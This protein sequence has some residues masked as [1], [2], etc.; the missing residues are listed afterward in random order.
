M[1]GVFGISLK[2]LKVDTIADELMI[3]PGGANIVSV[4]MK[5]RGAAF[6]GGRRGQGQSGATLWYDEDSGR[7]VTSSA[8]ADALPAWAE[9]FKATPRSWEWRL[10]PA[11]EAFLND[12]TEA[13][14][15]TADAQEGEAVDMGGATFPHLA[16]NPKMYRATPDADRLVID[17]ALAAIEHRCDGAGDKA[18]CGRRPTL[19]SVSLSANDYIGHR[20]GP[21]SWE[22]W[23]ELLRLDAEL[24]RFLEKLDAQFGRDGYSVLLTGDHG[25]PHLP[26]TAGTKGVRLSKA[27]LLQK[28]Q[29]ALGEAH[30]AAIIRDVVDSLV[31]VRD[32]ARELVRQNPD[33]D[34]LIRSTLLAQ[35]GVGEVYRISDFK[36]GCGAGPDADPKQA[37]RRLVCESVVADD[38]GE[39]GDYYIV[40]APGSFFVDPP[41]VVSHGSPYDYDREVPLLIRYPRGKGGETKPSAKFTSFHD[42]LRYALTGERTGDVIGSG[43]WE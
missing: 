21:D 34:A 24:K 13:R 30:G 28:L 9:K 42:S 7:V 5:D 32:D 3:R 25:I 22:A 10:T 16:K 37:M 4:S 41:D 27:A 33:V 40:P 39:Y 2:K 6:G 1:P 11:E 19:V 18:E 12:R 20:F 29:D 14:E 36:S 26:E 35:P 17:F 43:V 8:F 38:S 31:F 15:A 23:D